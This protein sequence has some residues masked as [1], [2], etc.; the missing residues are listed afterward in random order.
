[1]PA[2]IQDSSRSILTYRDCVVKLNVARKRKWGGYFEG[3]PL[4]LLRVILYFTLMPSFSVFWS[5][6]CTVREGGV[7]RIV[8]EAEIVEE[9]YLKR[10]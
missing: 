2:T 7:L 10:S 6:L 3:P 1:M 5:C 8:L 9:N 4:S